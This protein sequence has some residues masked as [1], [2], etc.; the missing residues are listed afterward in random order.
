MTETPMTDNTSL[1]ARLEA[2]N[3]S[4]DDKA[5]I[6]AELRRLNARVAELEGALIVERQRWWPP[7]YP[8]Q[9]RPKLA[10]WF[11]DESEVGLSGFDNETD[12][13]A[14]HEGSNGPFLRRITG[15]ENPQLPFRTALTQKEV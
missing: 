3:V 2:W 7:E 5:L 15:N 12:R 14:F 11:A 4:D 10:V 13:D 9:S 1:I 8:N 6:A